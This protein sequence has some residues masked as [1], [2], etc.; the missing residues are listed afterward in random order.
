MLPTVGLQGQTLW[1]LALFLLG[2][3][4]EDT[5][6]VP[7]L[8]HVVGILQEDSRVWLQ[9]TGHATFQAHHRVMANRSIGPAPH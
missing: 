4:R 9:R 5:L 8:E 1:C 3:G 6:V 7:E 2:H